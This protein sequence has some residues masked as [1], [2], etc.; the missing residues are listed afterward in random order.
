MGALEQVFSITY[1]YPVHQT[2]GVF[3]PDNPLLAQLVGRGAR[4]LCVVDDGAYRHHPRLLGALGHYCEQHGLGLAADC[5][6]LLDGGEAAKTPYQVAE[7]QD[8][9]WRAGLSSHAYVLAV[10]GGALIDV[11][12]Y[13]VATLRVAPR[14]IRFP[15]TV[16]AQA[17]ASLGPTNRLSPLGRRDFGGTFAPPRA[18]INDADFLATLPDD[19]WQVGCAHVTAIAAAHDRMLFDYLADHAIALAAH[20]LGPMEA[21]IERCATWRLRQM[22]RN[23]LG[24][25]AP[26]TLADRLAH[27][28]EQGCADTGGG[29]ATA[30]G[31]ALATTYSHLAGLLDRPSWER[32]VGVLARLGFSLPALIQATTP[33]D[34]TDLLWALNA[35]GDDRDLRAVLM[36]DIGE[37]VEGNID[38]ALFAR[39]L[40]LL[41]H[42]ATMA[43][44]TETAS[45]CA[46]HRQTVSVDL[47]PEAL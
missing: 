14:L 24:D 47:P 8:A 17:S 20:D 36:Q 45:A 35:S 43:G 25:E 19:V 26:L 18:V 37:C 22:L 1:R 2:R 9:I 10:G 44:S 15:T 29:R 38:T 5:S 11:V 4:L 31:L 39:S 28:I 34:D 13:A 16:F 41:R 46:A 40:T 21:A 6:L 27:A 30:A 12:G 3:A 42:W 32:V 7:V 23:P 33:R